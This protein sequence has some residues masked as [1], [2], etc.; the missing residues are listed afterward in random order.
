MT[1][2]A[3]IGVIIPSTNVS[4]ERDYVAL[5]PRDVSFHTARIFIENSIDSDEKTADNLRKIREGSAKA[6][7]DVGTCR[8]DH[9]IMGMSSETFVGG[10]KGSIELT[11]KMEELTGLKV[12]TGSQATSMILEEIGA[13]RIGVLTPYQPELD[14]EV[15][16]YFD[17]LGYEMVAMKSLRCPTAVSIAETSDEEILAA[18][19]E[20]AQ[21]GEVD[22]FVQAGTNLSSW[23]VADEIE[24][25]HG[26]PHIAINVATLVHALRSLGINDPIEGA[27]SVFAR[28]AAA[29]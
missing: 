4:V 10:L 28:P 22:A 7:H 18:V 19:D 13:R 23:R 29:A 21:A 5:A 6:A 24:R 17:D 8:P 25:R 20:L 11:K 3:K 27:G 12:S 1:Y 14:G 2:R 15:E 16:R 26:K 9:L